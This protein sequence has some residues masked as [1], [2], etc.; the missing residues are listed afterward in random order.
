[1]PSLA[2][3]ATLNNYTPDDVATLRTNNS[4][5]QY[6]IVGHEVGEQGTPHL[7]MYFQLARQTKLTTIKNWGGPWE[8]MHMAPAKGQSDLFPHEEQGEF[9]EPYSAPGYCMKDG[10]FFEVGTKKQMGKKG[11]RNDIQ[12]ALQAVRSGAN[13]RTLFEEHSQ[14]MAKYP[15]FIDRYRTIVRN[16]DAK[17]YFR[18]KFSSW[19]LYPWQ[20]HIDSQIREPADDRSITW[21]WSDA[22]NLG[23]SSFGTYLTVHHNAL[24]IEAGKKNDIIHIFS[25]NP[26]P[27]VV[28]DLVKATKEDGIDHMYGFAESLKNGRIMTGKY[29]GDSILFRPP[30]VIF[31]ANF[32]PDESKWSSDRLTTFKLD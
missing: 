14:V 1:M 3:V 27:V 18:D 15:K 5:I 23:K 31:F 10:N 25:K 29:D 28:I 19:E 11:A 16:D 2:Y 17:E 6:I 8:R 21:I 24:I 12:D 20:R 7:Q 32:P 4:S 22:G 30:H 26:A 13:E 9:R